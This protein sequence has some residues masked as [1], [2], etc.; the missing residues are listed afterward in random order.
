VAEELQRSMGSDL[1]GLNSAG[2]VAEL[3]RQT[4]ELERQLDRFRRHP[5]IRLALAARRAVRRS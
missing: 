2:R 3:E 1:G 4:A 5:M